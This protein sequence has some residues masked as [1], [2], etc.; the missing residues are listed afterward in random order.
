MLLG[1]HVPTV[2]SVAGGASG[3]RFGLFLEFVEAALDVFRDGVVDPPLGRLEV[4]ALGRIPAGA[5]VVVAR[6]VYLGV[7]AGLPQAIRDRRLAR[8]RQI[9]TGSDERN[10]LPM[11]ER[12]SG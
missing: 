5:L 8:P 3:L 1:Q 12:S 4:E 7:L 2:G 6:R 10:R 9:Y 11:S